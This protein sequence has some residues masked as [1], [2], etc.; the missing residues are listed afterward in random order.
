MRR[1]ACAFL[2]SIGL[3]ACATP[4]A[5]PLPPPE[6]VAVERPPARIALALG[7]GAARGFAHVGVI[8]ALEAQG[9]SPDIVVGTSA[10]SVV[11]ALY[12]AGL[13]GFQIQELSMG[14]AE[15]Q[16]VDGSGMYRCIAETAVSNKRGCIKG[17]AL[18]DFVN[19]N[20][21]GRPIERLHKTFAAVATHLAS[22]EMV[23]FRTGN[24]GMAVRASSSVPVFFE[25]VN[26]G[27]QDYVDGG[28][29]APVPARV[30]RS[31]GADF[32]IAVDISDR[33]QDR[34]TSGMTD[35][36]WQTF[37]IFGQT[38]N[39]HEHS[40]ADIVIRPVTTGLPSADV[41]GRNKAV[42]EGEKAVAAI[43][44]E[45]KAKLAKLNEKKR[46]AGML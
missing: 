7:G 34:K 24:T 20:V 26:I 29:V 30:A 14:M 32:V 6:P 33:P 39:R 8:K 19:K 28:L 4:P 45:L 9:I 38:L 15:E 31:I 2:W 25:P 16:V 46:V 11:G 12:A 22:G 10:G 17:Q 41:S 42:L 44:P 18:Q 43:L 23:V 3:A 27:G 5:V 35:I 21:G 37:S 36:L 1:L 40:S 13:N